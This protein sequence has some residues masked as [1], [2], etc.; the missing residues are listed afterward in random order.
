MSGTSTG[1]L[2]FMF[3][4]NPGRL[5][6]QLIPISQTRNLRPNLNIGLQGSF[7]RVVSR[8]VVFFNIALQSL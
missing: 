1:V 3:H 4:S 5:L 2:S 7:H 6:V 8:C